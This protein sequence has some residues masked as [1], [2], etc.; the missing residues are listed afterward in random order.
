MVQVLRV[1]HRSGFGREDQVISDAVLPAQ[2]RLQQALISELKQ[3]HTQLP[4][5]V[6]TPRL[7]ALWRCKATVHP[8][9]L[10]QNVAVRIV[11]VGPELNVTPLQCNQLPSS[12]AGPQGSEEQRIKCRADFMCRCQKPLRFLP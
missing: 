6:N 8:I 9:P 11:F 5:K 10:D 7:P 12:Q 3:D 1:E 4:R 2:V